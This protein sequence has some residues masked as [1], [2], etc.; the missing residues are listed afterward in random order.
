MGH[1]HS[2]RG[3]EPERFLVSR[4][5]DVAAEVVSKVGAVGHV[6]H[7]EQRRYGVALFDPEVL[8]NSGVKLK[9]RLSAQIVERG[10]GALARPETIPVFDP[11]G[12]PGNRIARISERRHG[13]CKIIGTCGEDHDVRSTAATAHTEDVY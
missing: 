12:R 11:I 10:K 1:D 2:S 9:E 3:N 13:G 4:L 8:A 7:L 6:E 5:A